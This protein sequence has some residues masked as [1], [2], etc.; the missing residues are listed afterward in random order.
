MRVL[1]AGCGYVGAALGTTLAAEGHEVLGL[2]RRPQRLPPGIVGVA[3]D[4]TDPASVA[5]LPSAVDAVVYLVGASAREEGAYRDAYVTGLAHL[6]AHLREA[7]RPPQRLLFAS[8]TAVYAQRRGEWVDETSPTE[9]D[10]FSGRL[11]L[12]GEGLV[13][14][15]PW[16]GTAVRFGGIYGPGRTSL[17]ERVRRGQATVAPG[18]PRYTNRIHRDDCAG[19][20]R[21]L[22]GPVAPPP[23]LLAVDREPAPEA[24]VLAWL[25]VRLGAPPPRRAAPDPDS[26]RAGSNKRCS[27]RRLVDLG[28]EFRFPTFREGYGALLRGESE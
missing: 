7:S 20:L 17:V 1:I 21:F 16:R 22:L 6:L 26:R 27:S 4:L 11:L 3:A 28:Y 18:P 2:R 12:E 25:A 14:S 9:P 23:V 13:A 8:S 10:H 5:A 19:V 15:G 24:E